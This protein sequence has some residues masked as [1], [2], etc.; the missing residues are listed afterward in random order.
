MSYNPNRESRSLLQSV[1]NTTSESILYR[2][3]SVP[4]AQT[5]DFS[6]NTV[7]EGNAEITDSNLWSHEIGSVAYDLV[8]EIGRKHPD[9]LC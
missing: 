2:N 8:M 4:T 3:L 6:F 9:T 7:G 5:F 1:Y